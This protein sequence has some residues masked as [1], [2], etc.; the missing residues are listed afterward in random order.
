LWDRWEGM[1]PSQRVPR[2]Y[3]VSLFDVSLLDDGRPPLMSS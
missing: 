1:D 2:P 3:H